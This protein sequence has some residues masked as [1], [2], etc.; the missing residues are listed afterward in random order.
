VRH[1]GARRNPWN[2]FECG[3]HYARSMASWA[4]LTALSGY[5][6]D[7]PNGRIGFT[8]RLRA[9][10]FRTFWSLDSGWGS[11]TQRSDA[12]GGQIVLSVAYG[13]LKLQALHLGSLDEVRSAEVTVD[14]HSVAATLAA[15]RV[16]WTVLFSE[17]LILKAGQCVT[18][19]VR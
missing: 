17:P 2:E 4:V 3:S 19:R 1:D 8:P 7:V 11:Y 9:G 16:G 6:F 10:D 5:E 14:G 18:I 15:E 13:E 12:D